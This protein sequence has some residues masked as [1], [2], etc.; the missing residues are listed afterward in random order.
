MVELPESLAGLPE[1]VAERVRVVASRRYPAAGTFV[2]HW[3]HTALRVE[4]NPALDTARFLATR[5]NLPLLVYQGLSERY[6]YACDRHH[7]FILQGA[8][9]THRELAAAGIPSVFHLERPGHRGPHL[10]TLAGRAAAVVTEDFP[11]APISD[12]LPRVAERA[13]GPV[14][15]VDTACVV[16]MR[17][18]GRAY[19]RA[20]SYRDAT[21]AMR[22]ARLARPWFT[23]A[24]TQFASVAPVVA[25]TA[26][27][28][29]STS[30]STPAPPPVPPSAPPS[31]S[32]SAPPSAPPPAPPPSTAFDLPFEPLDWERIEEDRAGLARLIGDCDIDHTVGPIADTPGG[33]RAGYER[34]NAFRRSGLARYA[35][36]RN[37]PLRAGT[38]RLSAYLRYGMVSPLRIA[39]EAAAVMAAG[40]GGKAGAE[41]FLDELLV[42]RELAYT[43]CHYRRDHG[44]V[45]AIP[46][47]AQ[48]TL[49]DHQADRRPALFDAESLARGC[50][51]DPLWD[52][53]QRSLRVRGELHNN[54]RMTWGKA[55]V[56]WTPDLATAWRHL[57]DL[58]HQFALDGRDPSSYGGLLWCVGQFDRPFTPPQPV[59]GT[60][61]TRPL[62]D[63]AMRLDPDQYREQV[64]R[65]AGGSAPRVAVIGAGVA[66]LIA[67]RTLADSGFE[68]SVF[69]KSRG[70]GGRAATR[71]AEPKLAFDHGAQY[72]TAYDPR[73][74]QAVETWIEQGLAAR[75]PAPLVQIGPAGVA[76]KTDQP[77]RFVFVPGMSA[78]GRHL[79]KDLSIRGD[80]RIA[81]VESRP[82]GWELIDTAGQSQGQFDYAVVA[83]PSP[84]AADL[85][86]D[87]PFAAEARAVPMTPC[88]AAMA[89]FERRVDTA[90]DGAFLHE[91][92]LAWVSRNSAKPGR[93]PSSDCWVLHATADWTAANLDLPKDEAA[94]QLLAAFGHSVE[95]S[96]A[97][98]QGG[99]CG[100]SHSTPDGQAAPLPA[101]IH[102][103]AHRW[104]FS[105]TPLTLDRQCLWDDASQLALCGDWLAGGRIEGAY[106]SGAA[107]AGCVLRKAGLATP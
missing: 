34:W 100:A 83:V 63:H 90:W 5:L 94:R 50:T 28:T 55:L 7:A 80:L 41:K 4:E 24:R 49:A 46:G 21:A 37:D 84:Q 31:A 65:P 91:S 36:D 54:V 44:T 6:P 58:N 66:G 60:V 16:P 2:L 95:Q 70:A 81:R 93:D 68:V 88:W 98:G 73:F 102:L 33:S 9:E 101:T 52:A 56:G 87:H 11:T 48:R 62:K 86:G 64:D 26:A 17:L 107:A 78:I 106:R 59:F 35:Y 3:M 40:G 19:D 69:E 104:M 89:A 18:V 27:P 43:F 1:P 45:A 72:F 38:S 97:A 71:R 67:A 23:V 20:F 39:R 61:R 8:R 42:W 13:A 32:P 82:A 76:A 22:A 15:A 75:W 25:N 96:A 30:V 77:E 14:F 53:A 29:A 92:P 99:R 57:V 79:A 10:R 12:W 103:D 47:W 105:A 74:R 51:G 85:L